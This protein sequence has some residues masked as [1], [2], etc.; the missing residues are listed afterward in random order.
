[1]AGSPKRV[2]AAVSGLMGVQ[3]G[4]ERGPGIRV[5]DTE[6]CG[7][8]WI[9]EA[10]TSG[11]ARCPS[12]HVAADTLN[13]TEFATDPRLRPFE[14][15]QVAEARDRILRLLAEAPDG[16]SLERFLPGPDRHA[17]KGGAREIAAEVS[18]VEY[19]HCR[20]GIG[21]ARHGGAGP[22]E[23][24][25][26]DPCRPGVRWAAGLSGADIRWRRLKLNLYAVTP[27]FGSPWPT[28][29]RSTP[30]PFQEMPPGMP[31]YTVIP[32]ADQTFHVA[33]VGNDGA[34]QTILGFQ[35]EA[36][37][38]AWIARDRLQSTTDDFRT[39]GDFRTLL[40]T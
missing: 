12:P 27:I 29:F 10:E 3:P 6:F 31:T 33:I 5:I 28:T 14:L 13:S 16:G 2:S 19:V 7:E 11:D 8:R 39:P 21:Q 26:G 25:C 37:A 36:D 1:M 40:E 32:Q 18:L 4:W 30:C 38:A 17:G 23:G 24:F 34:R 22:G 15:Y 20:V 35:T 9:V